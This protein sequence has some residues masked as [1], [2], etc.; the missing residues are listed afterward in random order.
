MET[1]EG[2]DKQGRCAIHHAKPASPDCLH[3]LG[4]DLSV[5]KAGVYSDVGF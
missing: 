4:G 5:G 2:Q 3:I 1:G